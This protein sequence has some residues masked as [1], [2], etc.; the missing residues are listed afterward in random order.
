MTKRYKIQS[1]S[2]KSVKKTFCMFGKMRKVTSLPELEAVISEHKMDNAFECPKILTKEMIY[3]DQ[4]V[5]EIL[6][7]D[8]PECPRAVGSGDGCKTEYS[9]KE[10]VASSDSG[11]CDDDVDDGEEESEWDKENISYIEFS[12]T[13]SENKGFESLYSNAS[14]NPHHFFCSTEPKVMASELDYCM[15]DE[16]EDAVPCHQKKE[17]KVSDEDE[18]ESEWSE[19]DSDWSD[20]GDDE[21]PA[22]SIKFW[23]SFLN[24]SDPYNPLYIC[25]TGT[26]TKAS[27][28]QQID[29]PSNPSAREDEHDAVPCTKKTASKVRFS[30]E[31]TV[32]ILEEWPLESQ[33]ARAGSCW[34]EMAIDRQRFK[35]RVELTEKIIS[36]YLEAQHRA[37]V[38]DRLL[39]HSDLSCFNN[40][41]TGQLLL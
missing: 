11:Y 20:E 37:K 29:T 22:E 30:K 1:P 24:K 26:K 23:N 3:S 27:E 9:E 39:N 40:N 31:V 4:L 10:V 33:E 18:D 16:D 41:N 5:A 17:T 7:S 34:M 21:I 15:N 32:H 25:L 35:R 13:L 2:R 6:P 38:F 36:P 28:I 8:L 19:E 14:D 12:A